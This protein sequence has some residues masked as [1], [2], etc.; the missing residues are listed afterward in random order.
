MFCVGLSCHLFSFVVITQTAKT[1]EFQCT[2]VLFK[3]QESILLG[4]GTDVSQPIPRNDFETLITPKTGLLLHQLQAMEEEIMWWLPWGSELDP[5]FTLDPV[6]TN[7]EK[8]GLVQDPVNK[9]MSF[10]RNIVRLGSKIVT[11]GC[12]VSNGAMHSRKGKSDSVNEVLI[13]TPMLL[14]RRLSWRF[15]SGQ[16]CRLFQFG[17][18]LLSLKVKAAFIGK[19]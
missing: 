9:L 15:S 13:R 11:T 18:I 17:A 19:F 4:N 10:M 6:Y 14:P 5:A 2:T 8:L 1:S 16:L 12:R 3:L 7:Q